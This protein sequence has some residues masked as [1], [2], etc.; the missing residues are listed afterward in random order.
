MAKQT[1]LPEGE[2][3]CIYPDFEAFYP[4]G[5]YDPD[6]Q[7]TEI[8]R[9]RRMAICK[10]WG[11]SWPIYC[12]SGNDVF[13]SMTVATPPLSK[14]LVHRRIA[15]D[16]PAPK[17]RHFH[18]S[19][20]ACFDYA[21]GN[22]RSMTPYQVVSAK[23]KDAV[24]S[25]ELGVHQFFNYDLCYTD[26]IIPYYIFHPGVVIEV[27]ADEKQPVCEALEPHAFK[28]RK[29]AIIGRHWACQ[30]GIGTQF[31]SR[32]LATRLLPLLPPKFTFVPQRVVR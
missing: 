23:W 30:L 5:T 31:I 17:I 4:R 21:S 7:E 6:P 13:S 8:I 14:D 29:S 3:F 18:Y 16:R 19:F 27:R 25:V 1:E 12:N 24:E 10:E 9:S 2:F 26:K 32:N 28:L 15:I 11:I 22:S 20:S